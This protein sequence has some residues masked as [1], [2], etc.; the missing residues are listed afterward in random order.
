MSPAPDWLRWARTLQGL[1]QTGLHYA[2]DPFDS[3]RYAAVRRIAAEIAASGANA[4]VALVENFFTSERGYP[5]PKIDVRAAVIADGRIL[6]VREHDDGGWSMPGGWADVGE[7]ASEAAVRETHEEAG[8][9]VRAV[10]LIALYE[11]ERRGHPVHPE[12]SYKVFFLCEPIDGAA[13]RSAPV[14]GSHETTEAKWFERGDLPD[15]SLARIT[16]EEVATAFEHHRDP[17]LAS[18]FD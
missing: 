8:V 9:T 16:P 4:D 18:E 15:L 11:R 1:A 7:S 17:T 5:T 14:P 3:E 6:P 2:S 10:K 12:F 13:E